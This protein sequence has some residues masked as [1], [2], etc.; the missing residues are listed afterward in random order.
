[1]RSPYNWTVQR[2]KSCE[3]RSCCNPTDRK[4]RSGARPAP[5]PTTAQG[6]HVWHRDLHAHTAMV[7]YLRRLDR[8][9]SDTKSDSRGRREKLLAR[10]SLLP[11]NAPSCTPAWT[12]SC[13]PLSQLGEDPLH[14]VL[15]KSPQGLRASV[16][17]APKAAR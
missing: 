10:C 6:S 15:R 11:T 13:S 16:P 9:G 1:M 12:G 2:D 3:W 14:L 8:R 4:T 17:M 5:A 7:I